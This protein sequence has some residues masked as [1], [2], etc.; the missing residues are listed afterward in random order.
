MTFMRSLCGLLIAALLEVSVCVASSSSVST[1][2]T[3]L[4]NGAAMP[5]F[6]SPAVI[7]RDVVTS[8][9]AGGSVVPGVVG[10]VIPFQPDV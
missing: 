7:F 3:E 5:V 6:R 1:S 2:R 4:A 8:I 9:K 10:C